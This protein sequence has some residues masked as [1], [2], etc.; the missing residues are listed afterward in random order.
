MRAFGEHTSPLASAL[1]K[2]RA[3]GFDSVNAQSDGDRVSI[4]SS[5]ESRQST[6]VGPAARLQYCNVTDLGLS[7]SDKGSEGAGAEG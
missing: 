1:R 5:C 3:K 2:P 7:P 4:R 6:V